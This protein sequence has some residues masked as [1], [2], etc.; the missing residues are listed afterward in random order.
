MYSWFIAAAAIL[1][2]TVVPAHGTPIPPWLIAA[3]GRGALM[4]GGSSRS[5]LVCSSIATIRANMMTRDRRN[6]TL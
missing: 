3:R 4:A 6:C 5:V 2:E 1:L